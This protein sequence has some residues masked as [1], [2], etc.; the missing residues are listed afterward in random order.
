MP[1]R[2][3]KSQT[4]YIWGPYGPKWGPQLLSLLR[5]AFGRK[6]G[7]GAF[8]VRFSCKDALKR[9]DAEDIDAT[10]DRFMAPTLGC[11]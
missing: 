4:C 6:H 10:L 3:L 9:G 8:H 7:R 2:L 1:P 11:S 5:W